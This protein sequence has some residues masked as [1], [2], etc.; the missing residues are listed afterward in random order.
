MA[1]QP[2]PM[3]SGKQ[4]ANGGARK[5][6]Q[7]RRRQRPCG[8][9]NQVT[10]RDLAPREVRSTNQP[11]PVEFSIKV[12]KRIQLN[13]PIGTS[14]NVSVSPSM[15][16]AGVPGG[17]TYWSRIRV[18]KIEVWSDATAEGS[19]LLEVQVSPDTSWNQPPFAVRDSGTVGNERAHVGF[20]LGLLDRA[21]WFGTADTTELCVVRSGPD[22]ACILQASIELIS[23]GL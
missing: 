16:S 4:S 20:K 5:G 8:G 11:R 23:P 9:G 13:I 3:S 6:G 10:L 15:L 2:A 1:P 17:L 14:G 22:T 19:D 21:R 7:Q 12:P 18:E